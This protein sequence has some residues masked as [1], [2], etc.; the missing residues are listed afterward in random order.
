MAQSGYTPILIYAS[1]TTGNT[2]SAS[3]LTS[4]TSGAELALNYYDGKLFYKDNSGT[5]QVLATKG[6]GPIGGS[7][8]Q[9]QYNSSGALAGSSN[10]TFD[11]TTLT[12][13]GLITGSAFSTYLARPPA[14]GGTTAAA[15]SFT[16][17]SGSTSTTTP[18]VQSSG[19]L[20]LNT[21]GTTTAVTFDTN[22]NMGLGVTPSAWSTSGYTALQLKSGGAFWSTS[23]NGTVYSQNTY[24][25]GTN[26]IYL[27][28]NPATYY[29][30]YNGTHIW[31]YA[32]SG[33]AGNTASF[34]QG[35][36]LDNN[37]NL[38]LGVTPSA[39]KS[40]SKAI[41][42]NTTG[43]V[44]SD[45]TYGTAY[46]DNVYLNSSA[47]WIRLTGNG[48]TTGLA[49]VYGQ[50]NGVHYWYNA[51]VGSAGSTTSL[52]QAMTLDNSG[53]LLINRA[54]SG[55]NEAMQ[56]TG[57]TVSGQDYCYF[58]QGATSGVNAFAMRIF[59]STAVAVVGSI[60]FSSTT[61]TYNIT[62]DRRLKTNIVDFTDSG[63]Y[64]DGFKPRSFTWITD[65]SQDI[66]F[67]TDE[68]QQTLPNAITGEANATKE[69]EYEVTPAVK[70]EQGNITTPAVMGTRT[71]PV[72]QQGDFSTSAKMA[73]IIAE[74]QSTRKRLA[75][76]ETKVGA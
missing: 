17:L 20:L 8:T 14:I 48:T 70:D 11:G 45:T 76:L 9:V 37:G 34:T 27:T 41:Q 52:T 33:T 35:L 49:A 15:G 68:Y 31:Q 4:S 54:V 25:N 67:I 42:I 10:L 61:T 59:S 40:T 6:T 30:Q 47:Q 57:L 24:F 3:N 75:T 39:W 2:P 7:N 26:Q 60:Q 16:T 65:N 1:G 51:P 62:S 19:S 43:G 32:A 55:A 18:I 69:E 66:G 56:V 53:R 28:T 63:K 72:Y 23:A 71:V 38:G 36:I 74:L 22:Q 12:V 5:V 13:N 73:I 58:A 21:N 46:S 29:Q 44:S 50:A 64:I